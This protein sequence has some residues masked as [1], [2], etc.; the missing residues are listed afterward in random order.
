VCWGKVNWAREP[1]GHACRLLAERG[2]RVF[3][4]GT[5]AAARDHAARAMLR[6]LARASGGR[7]SA[8]TTAED[9]L[10]A[11]ERVVDRLS[12]RLQP[13]LASSSV[14]NPNKY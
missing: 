8:A 3:T 13:G 4:V 10:G 11:C 1:E 14:A 12:D 6:Y 5:G 2:W 7:W 9:A